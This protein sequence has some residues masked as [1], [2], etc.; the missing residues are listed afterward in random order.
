MMKSMYVVSSSNNNW[1]Y[2]IEKGFNNE[3]DSVGYAIA[4]IGVNV[5]LLPSEALALLR[6]H[7]SVTLEARGVMAAKTRKWRVTRLICNE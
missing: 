6:K 2:T 5:N 3:V 1:S 7:D 4:N